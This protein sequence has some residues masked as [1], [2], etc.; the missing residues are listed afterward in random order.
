MKQIISIIAIVASLS[1]AAVAMGIMTTQQSVSAVCSADGRCTG[2]GGSNGTAG[3][4]GPCIGHHRTVTSSDGRN[5][6]QVC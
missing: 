3:T 6:T 4:V 1:L 5:V 2:P